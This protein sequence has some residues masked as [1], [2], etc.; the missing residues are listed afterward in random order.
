MIAEILGP[1]GRI[2]YRRPVDDPMVDEARRTPGYTVR[3]V[4]DE[5]IE[6]EPS[7]VMGK[8]MGTKDQY[9]ECYANGGR[10]YLVVFT[11]EGEPFSVF[12]PGNNHMLWSR[13]TLKPMSLRVA[14]AV[15][16]AQKVRGE[17]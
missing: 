2:H 3:F 4:E 11:A 15:R 7:A 16:A 10:R 5:T 12:T 1:S 14:C 17:L 8:V 13:A 9:T 6:Q